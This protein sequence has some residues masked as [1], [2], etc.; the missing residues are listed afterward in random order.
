MI[1]PYKNKFLLY[2]EIAPALTGYARIIEFRCFIDGTDKYAD[3][4]L[5]ESKDYNWVM[6]MTEG[7][8]K[9]GKK[10]GICR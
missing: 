4:T 2:D 5:E 1:Y 9:N 7:E 10:N 8:I 6:A 3:P